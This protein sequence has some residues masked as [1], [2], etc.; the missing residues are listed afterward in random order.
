MTAKTKLRISPE[1]VRATIERLG[2]TYIKLGQYFA[3]RPDLIPQEYCD[4]LLYLVDSAPSFPFETARRIIAEDLGR[5]PLECFAEFDTTP[6]SAASLSQVYRAVTHEGEIVAVKVQREN[7]AK[8]VEKDFARARLIEP[9]I[10]LF[11]LLPGVPEHEALEQMREWMNEELDFELERR[12][13]NHMRALLRNDPRVRIPRAFDHLSGRHVITMEYLSGISFSRLL[14]LAREGDFQRIRELGIDRDA[15]T[16]NLLRTCLDQT[17]RHRFFHADTHPGNI[18]AMPGAVIGFV[19]FGLTERL[20]AQYEPA[21][22][23][24]VSSLYLRNIDGMI[25]AIMRV[26]IPSD[27]ADPGAF[28]TEFRNQHRIWLRSRASGSDLDA[29]WSLRNYM[30]GAMRA[31]RQCGMRLPAGLLSMYRS[32]LT[33]ETVARQLGG[34]ADLMS[35]GQRF[36]DGLR[37]ER[38]LDHFQPEQVNRALIPVLDFLEEPSGKYLR[39]LSDI[40]DGDYVLTVESTES[41]ASRRSAN[42]R[43]RLITAAIVL[44]AIST[45]QAGSRGV[46]LAAHFP[47]S[48]LL[49]IAWGLAALWLA[50]LWSRLK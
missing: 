28:E 32:L 16:T 25:D 17:F 31:A 44:G 26:L 40:A 37:L 27:N 35:A 45:L 49:W 11:H 24:F 42:H 46:M 14:R 29:D 20:D 9:L 30:V 23:H 33:A 10:E 2:P 6:V 21:V 4:E 7:L 50:V 5:D 43:A 15:L 18:L 38:F 19:D 12:N 39:L 34:S 1:T 13:M 3:L 36:F 41:A 48:T 8:L 22:R 47:L